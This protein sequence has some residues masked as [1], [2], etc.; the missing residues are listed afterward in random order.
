MSMI[1]QADVESISK[2]VIGT[3]RDFESWILDVF[4]FLGIRPTIHCGIDNHA[5]STIIHACNT[6]YRQT[7]QMIFHLS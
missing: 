7:R 2:G 3:L 6:L 1:W 4:H 5:G